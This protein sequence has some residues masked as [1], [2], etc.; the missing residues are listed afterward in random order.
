MVPCSTWPLRKCH[1]KPMCM[2]FSLTK[3]FW[4]YAMTLWL[5]SPM[6]V[7]SVMGELRIFPRVVGGGVPPWWRRPQSSIR[8]YTLIEPH[9]SIVWTCS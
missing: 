1:F 7:V 6:V 5:S 8:L 4:E 2:V 3:A 9:K